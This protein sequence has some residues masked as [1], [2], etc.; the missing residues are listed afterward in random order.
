MTPRGSAISEEI[1]PPSL[2]LFGRNF[3]VVVVDSSLV[4]PPSAFS[5]FNPPLFTY[6]YSSVLASF[7]TSHR[8]SLW[9]NP[10][11]VF[12]SSF[13]RYVASFVKSSP[14]FVASTLL[15]VHNK[16]SYVRF[17]FVLRS[18]PSWV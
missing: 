13:L 15:R 3:I 1:F 4:W 17:P 16:V 6:V 7:S 2:P 9:L 5:R 11:S 18:W 8:P 10:S 14:S 12:E